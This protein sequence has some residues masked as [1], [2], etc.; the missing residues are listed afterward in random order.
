MYICLIGIH[1]M[2]HIVIQFYGCSLVDVYDL[3]IYVSY[4]M[5]IDLFF[6]IAYISIYI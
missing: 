5:D 2:K 3:D 6:I 1:M 4:F